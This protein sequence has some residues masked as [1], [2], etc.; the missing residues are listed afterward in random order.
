MTDKLSPLTRFM[1]IFSIIFAAEMI[2]TLPFH[3]PRFFRPTVLSAFNLSNADLGDIFAVYGIMAMLAYFPGG[4]LADRF[5]ARHLMTFSLLLTASGGLLFAQQPGMSTLVGLYAFWGVSTIFLFWA[6]M[7][8]VTRF[9]GGTLSQ[10]KAFGILDG[11][12]GLV[13]ASV[14]TLAVFILSY[15]MPGDLNELDDVQR[16]VALQ[17]VIYFY[18]GLT[19]LAA[20][21]V[22]LFIPI[23]SA[24]EQTDQL[25]QLPVANA[26]RQVAKLPVVWYQAGIVLAAYCCFKGLDYSVLYAT[27]VLGFNEV[28]ASSAVSTAAFM[29]PVAAVLAG[30]LADKL[31][32][33]A[34]I[35]WSFAILLG[36]YGLFVL[37]TPGDLFAGWVYV[38]FAVTYL[39]AFAIRGVYFALL[40]ET[41]IVPHL[42][43]TSVG[44][45]SLLGYT[46]DVFFAPVV[47]RILDATP[48]I[49]G[50]HHFYL[51]MAVIAVVGLLMV[52]GLSRRVSINN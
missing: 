5:Q 23:E 43:G 10:G 6:P 41:K 50:F 8:R 4:V 49:E 1:V 26:V 9:W 52:Y 45:I 37:L 38:N 29:R 30:V 2:F 25:A 11:G 7:I 48:G 22:W 16:Q 19:V 40:Q 12:R 3:V 31:T 32:T 51:L 44:I 42:T 21:L 47:G 28:E 39:L 27:D 46:P 20:V 24:A 18:T 13:A 14:A 34:V 33:R 17:A 36:C 15:L 35:R